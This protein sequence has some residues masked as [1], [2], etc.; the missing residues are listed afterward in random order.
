MTCAQTVPCV[1]GLS[2]GRFTALSLSEAGVRS[3]TCR[4]SKSSRPVDLRLAWV[5]KEALALLV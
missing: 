4:I 2:G 1:E 3:W 5:S